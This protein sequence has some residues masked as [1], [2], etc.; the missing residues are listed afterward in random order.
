MISSTDNKLLYN[1]KLSSVGPSRIT[2]SGL[3]NE[4]TG[5]DLAMKLHYIKGVYF[6]SSEASQGLTTPHIKEN[7][8]YWSNDYYLASGRFWRAED[9]R[10][11]MKCNDCGVRMIEAQ[12]DKT[13]EE[14]LQMRDSS[15]DSLLVYHQPLGPDLSFS[16][17]LYLQIT[18]F[19][20]GGISFGMSWAHIIG[21]MFSI[22][23][24]INMWGL[25]L[26]GLKSYGPLEIPKQPERPQKPN[27]VKN[28]LS[29]KRVNPV[30]DHWV[31]AND[32]KMVTFS[33]YLTDSKLTHLL[34]NISG[35]THIEKAPLFE[36]IC[37]IIWQSISKI[38]QGN[39]PKTVTI[40]KKDPN[41][42]KIRNLSNTQII[43]SVESQNSIID[44]DLKTLTKLLSDCAIDER[45]QIE[46]TVE[47]AQDY[48]VYG[49]NLTFIDLGGADLYGLEWNKKKPLFVSYSIQGVGDEGVVLVVPWKQNCDDL[50]N[51]GRV[52]TMILPEME[53]TKLKI[54][55]KEN[56]FFT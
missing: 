7:L 42:S 12:C 8:F 55:L 52:V 40:C 44:S 6:F 31:T 20:C 26:A 24:S 9:G 39:E 1:F 17:S 29:L 35:Q 27:N 5:I 2:G 45:D 30:G 47:G 4:P 33:L 32:C 46:N 49:A 56:G 11:Y 37:A 54:E 25:F 3:I 19:K 41:C 14:W 22:S 23:D 43:S 21:D 18:R 15:L 16:P 51:K 13:V 53:A 50:S 28:P 34:S 38:R 48:I 36:S 10:P